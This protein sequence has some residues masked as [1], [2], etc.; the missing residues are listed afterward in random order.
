MAK[1]IVEYILTLKDRSFTKGL[2]RAALRVSKVDNRT[3]ALNSNINGLNVG[4]AALVVGYGALKAV[5]IAGDFEQT[6]IAF[7]TMLGS[8]ERGQKLLR[9]L[10]VFATKTPFSI[11][12]VQSSA[13]QLLAMGINADKLLPTLKSLGDVSSGLS[14]PISR[15]ALN[16]GQVKS[17][18]KLTGRELRDF[19]I[20]GVP[21][22]AEL[23]KQLNVSTAQIT[24]LVSAGKIGF[25]EV[26]QAFTNMSSE[27]GRF[28]N[29]MDKQNKTFH[30][31]VNEMKENIQIL[32]RSIGNILI[33]MLRPLVKLISRAVE[34]TKRHKTAVEIAIK[35]FLVFATVIGIIIMQVK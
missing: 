29:L 15:L 35:V 10:D 26:E 27:G 22:T 21:L 8:V 4:I 19:A 2:K 3:K 13:K 31:G 7:E 14:V 23:A 5:K 24:K 9:E 34:F 25:P 1:N 16:F 33:P 20:A 17:Q 28:F 12:G 6:G 11:E 18:G 30:G 32:A